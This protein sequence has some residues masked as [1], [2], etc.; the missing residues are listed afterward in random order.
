MITGKYELNS[1]RINSYNENG[2]I[3]LRSV[4]SFEEINYYRDAI[5]NTLREY[6][7]ERKLLQASGKVDNYNSYFAQVTNLWLKN[8]TVKEFIL[9]EKFASIAAQLM[10]VEAVR[11]YHDQGL[12]KEPGGKPTPWHQDQYYWPI[13]SDKTITMWMPLVDADV[14][15]GTMKFASG[16]HRFGHFNDKPISE[17]TDVYYSEIIEKHKFPVTTN[18]LN[19]GDAT[20]HSGWTIHASSGNNRSITREVITIIYYADGVKIGE[21]DNKH[22][23]IDL[24]VFFP[25]L[26][27]GDT[28]ATQLNPLVYSKRHKLH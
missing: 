2:H 18:N 28:A 19:A 4:A 27:P 1:A 24:E 12:F 9:A 21:P 22:R 13:A 14:E 5:K 20:F 10:G 16:S 25:G 17:D 3:L 23:K 7:D 15:M 11:I 26:K 6:F 8:N